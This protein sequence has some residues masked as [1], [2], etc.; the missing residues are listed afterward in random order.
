MGKP[1]KLDI[2]RTLGTGGMATVH[3][4][5][6]FDGEKTRLVAIKTPHAFIVGDET[7]ATLLANE[8]RVGAR[9]RHR[10]VVSVLDYLELEGPV[11]VM[12]WIDG[13]DLTKLVHAATTTKQPIPLDVVAAIARDL[14]AGLSAAHGH[15]VVHRDVSPHNV[16]VGFDGIA[17]VTDFGIAKA[18]WRS[19]V[20]HTGAGIIKGKMRYLAPEQ[21]GG[22]CDCRSDVYAAGV[23]L[24]ELLTLTPL[25]S[26]DGVEALF[27]I[28]YR[29]VEP[30]SARAAHAAVFD[31]VLSRALSFRPEHRFDS[32]DEMRASVEAAVAPADPARV[33]RVVSELVASADAL[34]STHDE[35]VTQRIAPAA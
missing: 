22:L 24:W 1:R 28:L 23:V 32:A 6:F 8:A 13:V 26:T 33:A 17:R 14:L 34:P 20:T 16:L 3:L 15:E 5:R 25:R 21:L 27:E 35:I 30:P 29:D 7:S 18:A 12:E 31:A 10:N 19:A 11:L 9:I 2:V 4:A